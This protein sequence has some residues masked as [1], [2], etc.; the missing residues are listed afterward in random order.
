MSYQNI[1]WDEI[2][3][4]VKTLSDKISK[5]NRSFSN[6]VTVSRGGLV[7]SRLVADHLGIKKIHVDEKQISSDSLFVDDIFDS[8][9][10]FKKI[11]SIVDNPSQFIFTTLL[12]RRGKSYPSQLVYAKQTDDDNYVVFPWDKLEFQRSQKLSG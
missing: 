7:P 6:I 5:L 4:L 12:A 10:T 11:I 3:I 1:S 9:D 8:G 2:E